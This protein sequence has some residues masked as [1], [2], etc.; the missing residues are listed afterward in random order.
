MNE[1]M[2]SIMKEDSF[3]KL[4]ADELLFVSGGSC[5]NPMWGGPI[6]EDPKGPG[7]DSSGSSSS[8][9]GKS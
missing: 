9:S 7:S 4:S 6:I 8:S 1:I 5:Y 3:L 2:E